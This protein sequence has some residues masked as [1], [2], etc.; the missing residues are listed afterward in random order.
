MKL[1]RRP[2]FFY[3]LAQFALL[4]L[5]CF[6][7][8]AQAQNR[9][10][11]PVYRRVSL[12]GGPTQAAATQAERITIE[13]AP[14]AAPVAK[15]WRGV[16]VEA[17][18]RY[19]AANGAKSL[20]AA[21]NAGA[22]LARVSLFSL[23]GVLQLLADGTPQIA[24]DASDAQ[25][26]AAS[27]IGGVVLSLST[28]PAL[29]P[30]VWGA[31]VKSVA[32][33]YGKDPKF[34]VVRWEFA[35]A[36][37][38]ASE[39]YPVFARTVREVLPDA[40][41]GFRLTMGNSAD[42][43]NA[44]AKA[45]AAANV[46]FDSFGWTIAAESEDAGQATERIRAALAK[47]PALKSTRLLPDIAVRD[48]ANPAR[49]LTLTARLMA[50]APPDARNGLLGASVNLRGATDAFGRRG[51]A[52][53]ALALLNRMAGRQLNLRLDRA[54]VR[55]LATGEPGKIHLLLWREAASGEA[56][57]LVR[58]T[59]LASALRAVGVRIQRFSGPDAPDDATD[60]DSGDLELP[61]LLRPRSFL[62][63]EITPAPASPFAVSLSAPQFTYNPGETMALTVAIRNNGRAAIPDLTLR[64]PIPGLFNSSN[65]GAATGVIGAGQT[66][67]L[68][69][70]I[71]I[72]SLLGE[73]NI[74]LTAQVGAARAGLQIRVRSALAVTVETPRVDQPRPGQLSQA[75]LRLL[76]RG[77]LPL[78]V[79]IRPE[80]TPPQTVTVPVGASGIAC[81]VDMALPIFD[82]GVYPFQI[83]FED[84][85]TNETVE[86]AILAVG[87]PALCRRAEA[88]PN[89]DANLGD[90]AGSERLGMGRVEQTSGKAWGGPSD[91][92]ATAYTKWDAQFFYF[93]CDVADDVFTPSTTKQSL[94]QADSVQ[95]ALSTNR[96]APVVSGSYGAGDHEFALALLPGGAVIVR[97]AGKG[98]PVGAGVLGAKV[99]VRRIGTHTLYEA[100]VPWLQIGGAKPGYEAVLGFAVRVNDRDG[101][102]FG[103][104]TWNSGMENGRYPGRFPPL[105]LVP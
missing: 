6:C 44:L 99:A 41:I 22:N 58:L 84:P 9:P 31:L 70:S 60:A 54:D 76:N 69:Y 21:R 24:W 23:P 86:S 103:A 34:R 46:P 47:F 14:T 2:A 81:T 16:Y 48:G 49:I 78:T 105:R 45:C 33:H 38:Q 39:R 95:F 13:A 20:T 29:R 35:G 104:I 91:L 94:T 28:P 36:A 15:F 30:A 79:L 5:G 93:A 26:L 7:G 37:A 77:P 72:P 55:G 27:E 51:E 101:G 65:S 87:V 90:W 92:S 96:N 17:A 56:L 43:A 89:L 40:P 63:L 73:R 66:K 25:A 12:I 62:L 98:S 32:L 18:G 67:T 88:P 11:E 53:N 59:H 57:A 97:L 52:G 74:A 83:A 80:H 42:A 10:L 64:S 102:A 3:A 1:F 8:L 4:M 19:D 100:A 71:F 68:R 50:F 82:P 61:V 85:E 75:R